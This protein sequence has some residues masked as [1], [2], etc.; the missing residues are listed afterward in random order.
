MNSS[1]LFPEMLTLEQTYPPSP[2]LDFS[3]LLEQQFAQTGLRDQIKPGMRIAL[4]VGSR[5]ITNLKHNVRATPD[6]PTPAA[7]RPFTVPAMGSHAGATSQGQLEMLASY[8]VTPETM[9]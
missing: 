3:A 7:A 1:N 8:G 9:G 2:K 6:V 4:G 5:G